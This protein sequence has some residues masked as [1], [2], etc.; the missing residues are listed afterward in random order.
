MV[1]FWG[2]SI[3]IYRVAG[4]AWNPNSAWGFPL[5]HTLSSTGCHLF[6]WVFAILT[7]G[8]GNLKTVL[9]CI[10]PTARKS[11]Y[12]FKTFFNRVISSFENSLFRYQEHSFRMGGLFFEFFVLS[13]ILCL[14]EFAMIISCS[15]LVCEVPLVNFW[16]QFLGKWSPIQE[17]LSYT[18]IS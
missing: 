4:L 12:F 1:S 11:N 10:S 8:R 7:Q 13:V 17:V 2:F 16:P 14:I 5:L 3:V 18:C 6:C 9:V 15:V